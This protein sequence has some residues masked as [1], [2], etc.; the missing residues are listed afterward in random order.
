[1]LK[2]F[3]NSLDSLTDSRPA[4]KRLGYNSYE[5][6]VAAEEASYKD[7]PVYNHYISSDNV[8]TL[9]QD[10]EIKEFKW[11]YFTFENNRIKLKWRKYYMLQT[12]IWRDIFK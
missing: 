12:H 11:P 9:K 6:A 8:S 1:M 7:N 4:W 10:D 2:N 5:D 3:L